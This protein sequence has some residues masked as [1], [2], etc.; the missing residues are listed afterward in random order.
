MTRPRF[1]MTFVPLSGAVDEI[2][3]LR[4]VLKQML[5]RHGL[6]CVRLQPEEPTKQ[7]VRRDARR[8]IA[9]QQASQ[10]KRRNNM[11]SAR[12]F[13]TAHFIK[14]EDLKNKPP[15][16]ERISFAKADDGKY[17]KKLILFFESGK[18]LTLNTTSVDRLIRDLGDDY[19]KWNG[20]DVKVFASE[21]AFQNGMADCILVEVVGVDDPMQINTPGGVVDLRTGKNAT[22]PTNGGKHDDMD[23]PWGP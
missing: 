21:V 12:E 15:L 8:R 9:P 16:R 13:A 6:R 5:R 14:L 2:K 19:A 22:K 23:D 17:G 10:P 7:S 11:P 3:A 20:H 4:S 1:V 18:R